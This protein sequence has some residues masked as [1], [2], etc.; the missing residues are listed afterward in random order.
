MGL[1]LD[2]RQVDGVTIVDAVGIMD[3]GDGSSA[4]REKIRDLVAKNQNQI[5]LNMAGVRY[6]DSSGVGELVSAFTVVVNSG[7]SLKILA[8]QKRLEDLF[9]VTKLYTVFDIFNDEKGAVES[10]RT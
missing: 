10:F 8:F 7:G 2:V 3:L 9:K 5:L 4:F 1:Q 6:A